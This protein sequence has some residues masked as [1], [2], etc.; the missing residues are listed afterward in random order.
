MVEPSTVV[1]RPGGRGIMVWTAQRWDG[2]HPPARTQAPAPPPTPPTPPH[3]PP[4]ASPQPASRHYPQNTPDTGQ[5]LPPAVPHSPGLQ[6]V[7][8]LALGTLPSW[9]GD[10]G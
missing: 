5:A 3:P 2:P 4:P 6:T 10:F 8:H 7:T 9:T 1:T